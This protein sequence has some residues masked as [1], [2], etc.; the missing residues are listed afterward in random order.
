MADLDLVRAEHLAQGLEL[1]DLDPDPVV[2]CRAWWDRAVEV[3]VHQPDAVALATADAD[4]R[5]SV[6]YVLLRGLATDGLRFYTNYDSPKGRDLT[7]NP[8]AALDLAW[9]EIG[10]QIRAEGPVQPTTADD[11]DAYWASRPRASQ[12]AARVSQQSRP[13]ADRSTMV[14]AVAEEAARWD[15]QDVPRP[16]SW[17][18]FVLMPDRWEFWNGRPDRLHDRFVYEP[19]GSGGWTITRCWP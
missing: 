4:G 9:V 1:S 2:Q 17:G 11:S 8:H 14:E 16:D 18:G 15:G 6:R 12:L 3:G 19:D 10:R 5:P 7:V 13:V